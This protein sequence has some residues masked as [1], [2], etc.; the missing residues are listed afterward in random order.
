MTNIIK[1]TITLILSYITMMLVPFELIYHLF[2]WLFT[3]KKFPD[4]LYFWVLKTLW[5]KPKKTYDS[6]YCELCG[7]CGED[8]C[9]SYLKCFKSLIENPKCDYGETYLKDAQFADKLYTLGFNI[10][11][12]LKNHQLTSDEAVEEYENEYDIIWNEIYNK[13]E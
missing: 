9:C 7:G 2:K 8:G 10:I 1:N 13:K 3:G 6:S 5:I 11:Q 12:K 4:P